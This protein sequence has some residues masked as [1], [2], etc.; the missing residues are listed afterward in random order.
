VLASS[1]SN[2]GSRNAP[3]LVRAA[4]VALSR[5]EVF[6]TVTTSPSLEEVAI[7]EPRRHREAV[8]SHLS[9]PA[10]RGTIQAIIV[11]NEEFLRGDQRGWLDLLQLVGAAPSAAASSSALAGTWY[12]EPPARARLVD[13]FGPSL[14]GIGH[15]LC[16]GSCGLQGAWVEGWKQSE[17]IVGVP[18]FGGLLVLDSAARFRPVALV[19]TG[20]RRGLTMR[21]AYPRWSPPIDAPAQA[22]PA[23]SAIA[24]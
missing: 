6:K 16:A 7:V 5:S 14:P 22:L 4:L 1:P 19:G 13:G 3:A 12:L 21:F 24:G 2:V 23:P 20:S 10:G 17:V 9:G 8:T 15:V 11:G 18:S